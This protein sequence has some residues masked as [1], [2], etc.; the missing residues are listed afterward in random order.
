MASGAKNGQYKNYNRDGRLILEG[1]FLEGKMH[2]DN[3]AYFPDGTVQ[4]RFTYE[5]GKKI[6]TN[7]EYYPNRK[8]KTREV[9]SANGLELKQE[10]FDEQGFLLSEKK[11]KGE[12]HEGTWTYYLE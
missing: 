8:I 12:K 5:K 7:Y 10:N 1:N 3:V 4:H 6:G 2:G 11:Y 9:A